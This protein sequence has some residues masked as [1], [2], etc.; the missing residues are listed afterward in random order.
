M[1]PL[2]TVFVA[3][4]NS[5]TDVGLL[6]YAAFLARQGVARRFRFLHVTSQAANTSVE[7]REGLL[8]RIALHFPS[9]LLAGENSLEVRVGNVL[10]QLLAAIT[11]SPA[12]L[13]LVGCR[14][15]RAGRPRLALRLAMTAPCSIWM[16]PDGSPARLQRVLA[17]VDF[18]K[19]SALGLCAAAMLAEQANADCQALH[20]YRDEAAFQF[21]THAAE[22]RN[23]QLET[24]R[25][26]I[27]EA[28]C[29]GRN[30]VPLVEESSHVAPAV[31]RVAAARQ[32]DLI[33]LST[34]GRSTAASIL[35][36][37]ETAQLMEQSTLPVLAVKHEGAH[38]NLLQALLSGETWR[39]SSTHTN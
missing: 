5:P 22:T 3:L 23:E 38:L 19:H 18:S 28:R 16:T 21:P 36:G 7:L 17:P 24:T 13:L 39:Q 27:E 15:N 26:F 33:V 14:M 1:F 10:D 12:D 37:S 11:Q 29:G 8:A 20:I 25:R 31:L 6:E 32:S 9:P 34:R 4:A 35:L 30:V 2:E